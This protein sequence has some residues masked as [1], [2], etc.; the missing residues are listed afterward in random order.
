MQTLHYS[1][2]VTTNH[3]NWTRSALLD[4]AGSVFRLFGR[5]FPEKDL[6]AE[7]GEFIFAGQMHRPPIPL[8]ILRTGTVTIK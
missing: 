2:W 7:G 8:E 3:L 5:C 4:I 1:G 6:R